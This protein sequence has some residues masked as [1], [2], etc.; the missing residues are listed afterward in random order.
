MVTV[1]VIKGFRDLQEH[2]DRTQGDKF[3]ATEERA[4]FIASRLPGYVTY[5]EEADDLSSLKLAELRELAAERGVELPKNASKAK[6]LELLG[7]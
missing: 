6:A 3:Q 7:G 4:A 5:E 1:T 2:V